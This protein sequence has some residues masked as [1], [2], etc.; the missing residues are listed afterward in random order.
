MNSVCVF[1]VK[2]KT[3]Y[4]MRISDWSSDVCSSDLGNSAFRLDLIGSF[5][6]VGPDG[7]RILIPSKRSCI[8]L[9][10]LATSRSGERS[11]RW[12]QER[13]WGSR[14]RTNSQASLRRELSNLRPLVNIGDP[15]LLIVNHEAV[16]LDLKQEIGRAHV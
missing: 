12:L 5:R 7:A 10:M 6:L 4:D 16:A 9:A 13:L 15:P 11:R 3:A 14:E 2:Q 8:L 1:F